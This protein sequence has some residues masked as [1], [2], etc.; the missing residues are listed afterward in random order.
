MALSNYDRT[1][2]ER[3]AGNGATECFEDCHL[4]D[5]ID[6]IDKEENLLLH[7]KNNT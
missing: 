4:P 7:E 6:M 2:Y 1:Y 5:L 3:I